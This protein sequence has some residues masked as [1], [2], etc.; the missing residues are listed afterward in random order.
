MRP[1]SGSRRSD[2]YTLMMAHGNVSKFN[3]P[4]QGLG[5]QQSMPQRT[6]QEKQHMGTPIRTGHA[7]MIDG[8][9]VVYA[10]THAHIKHTHIRTHHAHLHMY[11]R[12]PSHVATHAYTY[13]R[14]HIHP[15]THI[16]THTHAH[17]PTQTHQPT[18]TRSGRCMCLVVRGSPR[19]LCP[20]C[21]RGTPQGQGCSRLRLR[22]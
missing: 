1:R 6:Q 18:H 7:T 3:T 9:D 14:Q 22:R 21:T 15:H 20:H 11:S 13:A 4:C 16:H 8:D 12:T 19:P 17:T 10:T 5:L 2:T